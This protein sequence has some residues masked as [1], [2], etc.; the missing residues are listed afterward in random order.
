MN[1]KYIYCTLCTGAL[2][3]E[4][5]AQDEHSRL[6][7]SKCGFVFY[8]NPTPTVLAIIEQADKLLLVKR[9]NEPFKGSWTLPGGF[10][11]VGQNLEMALKQE[12]LEELGIKISDYSYFGSYVSQYHTKFVMED[13]VC[14]AFKV[15]AD[16]YEFKIGSDVVDAKFFS[17]SNLPETV[18]FK[19]VQVIIEKLIKEKL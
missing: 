14:T 3:L 7:C 13:I 4:R 1:N 2:S 6:T 5:Q 11:E 15:A 9:K 16:N 19:D 17:K 10:V 8:Q 18:P 12:I